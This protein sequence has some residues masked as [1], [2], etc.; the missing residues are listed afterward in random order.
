MKPLTLSVRPE[1][2]AVCRV[3][4]DVAVRES[5]FDCPFWSATR[6]ENAL[7]VVLPQADVPSDWEAETGCRC[8][9]VHG[10][11]S[12]DQVGIL[13]SLTVPLSDAGISVL[14]ISTYDTD[15]L[16]VREADLP[17]TRRALTEAGHTV[18][19]SREASS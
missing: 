8:L 7:S 14:T 1:R 5:L 19:S 4:P 18:E 9:K 11:L 10:P 16:L 15:Y 12:F 3:G 2:F 6:T 17:T 13:A